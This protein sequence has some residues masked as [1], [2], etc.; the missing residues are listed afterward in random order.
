MATPFRQARGVEMASLAR[1]SSFRVPGR[2]RVWSGSPL[3][4]TSPSDLSAF[5]PG[6][7]EGTPP[8]P[9]GVARAPSTGKA[10]CNLGD[11]APVKPA[12]QVGRCSARGS[13]PPTPL[14]GHPGVWLA[15][16]SPPSLTEAGSPL[17]RGQAKGMYLPRPPRG[18][19]PTGGPPSS[20]KHPRGHLPHLA[21]A[22]CA[23]A[24]RRAP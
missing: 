3:R 18:A 20:P 13:N 19:L 5:R 1:S 6:E 22:M 16:P 23:F 10:M 24:M 11:K 7:V 8:P 9:S 17:D 14:M 4:T 15:P 21:G 2:G 12:A